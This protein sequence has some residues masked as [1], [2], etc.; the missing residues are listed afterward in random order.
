V[1]VYSFDVAAEIH[2]EFPILWDIGIQFDFAERLGGSTEQLWA[3]VDAAL[4]E[5]HASRMERA[6]QNQDTRLDQ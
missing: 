3:E 1:T 5:I 6:A 2:R 4:R